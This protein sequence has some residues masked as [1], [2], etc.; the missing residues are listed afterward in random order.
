MVLI[1]TSAWI[2]FLTGRPGGQC[3]DDVL[4][5][6]ETV[7]YTGVILQELLQGCPD[8]HCAAVI[9]KRFTPFIEIFPQRSTYR[10]A[11]KI[12]RDCRSRGYT[13][14]SSTDSLIAAC[15]IEQECPILHRDRDYSFIG[16]VFPLKLH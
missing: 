5:R 12:Y 3:V 8:E 2:D 9:E 16:K 15:A 4:A 14:R 6:E 13:I 1:D 10:L 7:A 11:A